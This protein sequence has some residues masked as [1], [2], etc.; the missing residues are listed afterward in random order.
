MP[1]VVHFEIAADDPDRA[2]QFYSKVFEWEFNKWEGPQD[3]WL[4]KT[5]EQ[6][7]PGINGGLFR[8]GGPVDSVNTVDVPSLDEAMTRVTTNGGQVVAP[9][10]AIP[11]VGYLAYCQDT[12]GNMFGMMEA[13][14]SAR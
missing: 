11:G 10:M 2:V 3:Y 1:R 4:I 9:K 14:Q 7:E 6:D 12:E 5:G 8:R 13:D